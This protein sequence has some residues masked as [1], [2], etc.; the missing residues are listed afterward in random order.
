[1]NENNDN[2]MADNSDDINS[3]PATIGLPPPTGPIRVDSSTS[4]VGEYLMS[5]TPEPNSDD[6]S[7]DLGHNNINN[8]NDITTTLPPSLIPPTLGTNPPPAL[9]P[10]TLGRGRP[11]RAPHGTDTQGRLP[12]PSSE[13]HKK[14]VS[15]GDGSVLSALTDT[16]LGELEQRPTI[17]RPQ[18]LH[19]RHRSVS[20]DKTTYV[21]SSNVPAMI[22]PELM[23]RSAR[24]PNLWDQIALDDIVSPM[25]SEAETAIFRAVEA[26]RR[27]QSTATQTVLPHVPND[28]IHTFEHQGVSAWSLDASESFDEKKDAY[29]IPSSLMGSVSSQRTFT[30]APAVVATTTTSPASANVLGAPPSPTRSKVSAGSQRQSQPKIVAPGEPSLETKLFG[31]A[32]VMRDI[33]STNH[34]TRL[35][36]VVEPSRRRLPSADIGH[37]GAVLHQDV[38]IHDQDALVHNAN[39]LFRRHINAPEQ[40][41]VSS[42]PT[43]NVTKQRSTW[44]LF[45]GPAG[46]EDPKKSDVSPESIPTTKPDIESGVSPPTDCPASDHP[47]DNTKSFRSKFRST[48][49]V[50][51][52]M[53]TPEVIKRAR[54]GLK[55]DLDVFLSFLSPRKK[56]MLMYTRVFVLYLLLPTL[57][58]STLLFYF[59]KN[60]KMSSGCWTTDD[61]P[62]VTICPAI[63]WFLNFLILRQAIAYLLGKATGI[64]LIDFLALKTRVLLRMFGPIATLIF[65]QSKGWPFQ[66]A[67]WAFFS[68]LLNSGDNDFAKHWLYYQNGIRMFNEENPTGDIT[69]GEWNRLILWTVILLSVAVAFKR[70]LVGLYLGQRT[71]GT[72]VTHCCY[73]LPP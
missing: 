34:S 36:N 11:P 60:P 49:K 66:L 43:P 30:T 4:L 46:L 42:I 73:Q 41:Q 40:P 27:Q 52:A 25:E 13:N 33:H 61:K 28:A 7:E 18:Q 39:L 15:I 47:S 51:M 57:G 9:I 29:S 22:R 72:S 48:M 19:D 32:A 65:V 12:V 69:N 70:F 21:P 55:E 24:P 8:I 14:Q 17:E 58:I 44:N 2:G 5:T 26:H 68:L 6:S 63:S 71:Y 53:Q 64:L 10:P 54:F 62:P 16:S 3:P 50:D 35:L 67:S 38:P 23:P 56:W 37:P 31:L 45:G 59:F 20:F 1:M